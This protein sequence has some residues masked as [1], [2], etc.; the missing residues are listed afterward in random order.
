MHKILLSFISLFL[1]VTN[2]VAQPVFE[3]SLLNQ[4]PAQ[5]AQALRKSKPTAAD[6]SSV[7]NAKRETYYLALKQMVQGIRSKYYFHTEFPAD[8]C[9]AL[10]QHA[11]VLVGIEYPLSNVTGASGYDALLADTKIRLAEEMICRMSKVI[12]EE[13][14]LDKTTGKATKRSVDSYR[15][16]LN[17]WNAP[18]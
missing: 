7:I 8:L 15:N 3:G 9:A 1:Y 4:L 12:Y 5:R 10:E 16:W 2:C 11:I 13:A 6:S 18:A 17:H 14:Y